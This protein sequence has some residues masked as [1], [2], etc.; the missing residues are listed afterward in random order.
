MSSEGD[1][2]TDG[3]PLSKE[4]SLKM[5][6]LTAADLKQLAEKLEV[7]EWTDV[8]AANPR[9]LLHLKSY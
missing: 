6:R 5:A 8:A 7:V 9:V 4:K 2:D 1:S 3:K